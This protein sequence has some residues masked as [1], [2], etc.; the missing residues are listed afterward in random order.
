MVSAA[1]IMVRVRV[2]VWV[3]VKGEAFNKE[4]VRVCVRKF[5]HTSTFN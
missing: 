5:S 2:M 3:G 4:W 1:K